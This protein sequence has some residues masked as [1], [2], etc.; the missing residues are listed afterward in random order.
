[1]VFIKQEPQEYLESLV[2]QA[3][4]VQRG[5]KE[6]RVTPVFRESRDIR[7]TTEF[8]DFLYVMR[9]FYAT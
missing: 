3:E 5:T 4:K 7:A 9:L 6:T 2:C 1:M 8:L